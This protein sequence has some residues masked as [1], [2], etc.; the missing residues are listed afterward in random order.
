MQER[1]GC[2][3]CCPLTTCAARRTSTHAALGRALRRPPSSR[4][5][6][7]SN[8]TRPAPRSHG[9]L[10]T[11]H[12]APRHHAPAPRGHEQYQPPRRGRPPWARSPPR[13]ERPQPKSVKNAPPPP[14][15][16]H[17]DFRRCPPATARQ[18]GGEGEGGGGYGYTAQ[19]E[20]DTGA[21]IVSHSINCESRDCTPV[22]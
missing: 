7:A 8:A 11:R 6:P 15:L 12:A 10:H 16:G 3:L 21:E 2:L 19:E 13:S 5:P 4:S 1:A 9:A 22:G 17:P 14:S 20:G 18:G